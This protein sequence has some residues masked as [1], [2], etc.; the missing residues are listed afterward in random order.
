MR[1]IGPHEELPVGTHVRVGNKFGTV[2]KA[3]EERAVPAGMIMVHTIQFT[4]R[5]VRGVGCRTS[6]P[7]PLKT[8]YT[9]TVNYSSINV[10]DQDMR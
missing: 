6:K 1:S 3:S 9:S 7:R 8:P 2:V 5:V 4:S 10:L